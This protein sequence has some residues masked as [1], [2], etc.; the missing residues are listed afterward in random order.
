MDALYDVLAPWGE[1]LPLICVNDPD[2]LWVFNCGPIDALDLERSVVSQLRDGPIWQLRK[3]VFKPGVIPPGAIFKLP[4]ML[5]NS[6]LTTP[7]LV[8]RVREAGLSGCEFTHMGSAEPR[9]S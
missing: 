4:Q 3:A 7:T 9:L 6:L 2:P 1:I 8:D 5:K